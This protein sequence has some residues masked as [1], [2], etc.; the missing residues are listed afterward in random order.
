MRE[1][2]LGKFLDR[3]ILPSRTMNF[4]DEQR[5]NTFVDKQA[6]KNDKKHKQPESLNVK[7]NLEKEELDGMQVFRFN[8]RHSTAKKILYIHGGY[9]ILQPSVFHWRFMDKLALSM[10]HEIVMPIYP[11]TPTYHVV[12]TYEALNKIYQQLL[13]EVEH[14][15]DI[16]LM[17][18]GSGAALALSFTQQL[19][20]QDQPLPRQLYL[21]SPLLDATLSNELITTE[22][23]KQDILVNTHYTTKVMEIWADELSLDDPKVSPLNGHMIGLPPIFI[24]GG[25][26]EIYNP[27]MQV[28]ADMLKAKSLDVQFFEYKKMIHNFPLFP[29][30]ESHKALNQI[31]YYLNH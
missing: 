19:V 26:R 5:F 11:K 9:N 17:G 24:F 12:D 10:L 1:K 20:E 2:L 21:I 14:S 29:I 7:S 25:S 3:Y 22:L 18:D 6:T 15:E 27:D 13:S 30:R 23:K 16:V 31:L 8:F 28:L 4:K